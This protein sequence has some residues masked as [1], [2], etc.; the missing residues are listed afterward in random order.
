MVSRPSKR[1]SSPH[2]VRPEFLISACLAG[3]ECTYKG[4]NNLKAPVRRL[5][6]S[7][8]AVAVCPEV[9]GGLSVPRE[10]AEIIG[11]RVITSSG[12]DITKNCLAGSRIA[13][14][15]AKRYGIRKAILKASSPSCGYGLVYDGTFSGTLTKGSGI[16]A[17]LLAKNGIKVMDEKSFG[18][19]KSLKN[20]K[21]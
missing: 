15:L 19:L 11:G 17:G 16:L 9:M 14:R 18:Q 10:N 2:K 6:L 7:S 20:D 4:K 3:I 21:G 13:L 12:K 1:K 8:R 5:F